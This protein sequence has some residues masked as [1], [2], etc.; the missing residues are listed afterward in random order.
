MKIVV[1][2][3]TGLIGSA[4]L[5]RLAGKNDVVLLTRRPEEAHKQFEGAGFQILS[6]SQPE[7]Q[8]F[9]ALENSDALINLSGAGIADAP[10]TAKRKE[11]LLKSRVEPIR[12]LEALLKH[13]D[14]RFKIILQASA[15]GYYGH[16]DEQIFTESDTVGKGYL[17]DLTNEW[18]K[19]AQI[20][21]PFTDRLVLLRT[22]VVLSANGGALKPMMLP[23]K[24]YAGGKIGS[25]RQWVSWIDI[26]DQI[27]AMLFLLSSKTSDGVYNLTAPEPVRQGE[28]AKAIGV[29]M[30]SPA[31]L[32]VPGAALRLM[33]GQMADEMLLKGTLVKPDKLLK[34]GYQFQ[35]ADVETALKH[36]IG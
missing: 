10:W 13:A 20:L 32:P 30:K 23:F 4:L 15:I 26:E 19:A 22:G 6:W 9:A 11:V 29:S 25:G 8:L 35:S 18:E 36:V 3:G 5:K 24:F 27:G 17:A 7:E 12:K 2:G 16:H 31:W 14:L 21:K 33:M 34:A 28:L 1:A